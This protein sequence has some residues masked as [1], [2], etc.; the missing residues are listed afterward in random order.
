MALR[1]SPDKHVVAGTHAR[2]LLLQ[3]QGLLGDPNRRATLTLLAKTIE[4]MGF[5]Q[6]D[7]INV[8]ERAHHL[9]LFSRL[10]AYKPSMFAHL[11]ENSRELF[12][13]WT[14]DA[15]AIPTKWFPHW[16][17]RFERYRSRI[18]SNA[19]WKSRI[20]ENPDE[21]IAQVLK[22]I[23]ADGPLQS[24]D[25][26]H[27]PQHNGYQ[28][29]EDGWWGWKPQK[30]AL[31]HLWRT[32][33]LAVARRINFQKVYDLTARVL[34]HCTTCDAPEV[35]AHVDWACRSALERL[36]IATPA[37][38]AA[39]WHAIDLAQARQWCV[40]A[41]SA[42]DI[43]EIVVQTADGSK[44]R[45]SFTYPNIADRIKRLP[46]DDELDHGVRLLS[47]FDPVLRDRKRTRRLFNFD[48]TFEA[49]TPAPK[50]QYGYYVLPLLERDRLIGRID[51]KFHRDRGELEVKG[52][53]LEAHAKPTKARQRAIDT[54]I[55][56]LADFIGAANVKL[57]PPQ[58]Q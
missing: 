19:W 21:L 51:A 14:H 23:E 22:R 8:I 38:I 32:G 40:R 44:P 13:H 16:K 46:S 57:K 49:F 33:E 18:R 45:S 7:T 4:Q 25:F 5:V 9:T 26:E 34:P 27:D 1:D 20:G 58:S 15:S 37:E 28:P 30:A 54:A 3:A 10:H 41:K 35:D 6:L 55:Q 52:L 47:P 56:Q 12:E 39:F 24:R 17:H 53:W 11:L 36:V 29:P 48:Y 2:R 42:G 43:I 31:E 50:R